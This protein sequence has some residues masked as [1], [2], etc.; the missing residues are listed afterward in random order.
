[1][2]FYFKITFDTFIPMSSKDKKFTEVKL[3]LPNLA[4]RIVRATDTDVKNFGGDQMQ[5]VSSV[6]VKLQY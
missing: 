4:T 2:V 5:I 1:M 6:K 3:Q